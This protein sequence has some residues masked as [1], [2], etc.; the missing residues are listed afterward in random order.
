MRKYTSKLYTYI[1]SNT[2]ISHR[3]FLECT[4]YPMPMGKQYLIIFGNNFARITEWNNTLFGICRIILYFIL[5]LNAQNDWVKTTSIIL[6]DSTSVII[7]LTKL[8]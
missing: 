4:Q 1:Q 6:T 3:F 7:V 2:I 8:Y 5:D